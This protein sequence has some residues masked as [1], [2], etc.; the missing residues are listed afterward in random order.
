M[1]ENG[2]SQI[3]NHKSQIRRLQCKPMLLPLIAGAAAAVIAGYN[4]MAPRSQLY[5]RTFIG[6]NPGSRRLALTFDDGP[7]DPHTLHLLDVLARHNVR[8]TFFMVGSFVDK[9]PDI[10]RA[11]ATAGHTIGNHT[12]THPT[13]IFRNDRAIRR[14]IEQ[15][16]RS[17]DDA[18]AQHHRLFRPPHGARTPAV[19]RT[20]RSLGYEPVM[21]SVSG[22]DWKPHSPERIAQTV[23]QQVRGGDVILLHDGG[24]QRFGADRSASV[25]ATDLILQRYL[26]EG[27]QFVT[28]PEMMRRTKSN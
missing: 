22:R 28:I 25:G 17:L 14:Q 5:G 1:W 27:Y 18:G 10:A 23:H 11:V 12:A 13:L 15:C 9:R 2:Q 16:A 8:A 20:V 7:N 24:H 4:T 19:L 21:W 3:T 26:G 6:E